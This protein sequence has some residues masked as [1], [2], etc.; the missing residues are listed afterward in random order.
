MLLCFSLEMS[1]NG[2]N[3][4]KLGDQNRYWSQLWE[5][6]GEDGRKRWKEERDHVFLTGTV[7]TLTSDQLDQ[8]TSDILFQMQEWVRDCVQNSMYKKCRPLTKGGGGGTDLKFK[9]NFVR[10]WE[11]LIFSSISAL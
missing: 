1:G 11:T 6:E 10:F 8:A 7:E 2:N 9:Y 3:R 5:A 4:G